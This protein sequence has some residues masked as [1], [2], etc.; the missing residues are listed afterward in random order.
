MKTNSSR[1]TVIITGGS[2]GIGRASAICLS[3]IGFDVIITWNSTDLKT[4]EIVKIIHEKGRFAAHLQLRLDHDDIHEKF[5]EIDRIRE[6][7]IVGLV[8]NAAINGGRAHFEQKSLQDWQEVFQVNVFSLVELCKVVFERMALSKGGNGGS[9]VNLSSQV[10][11]FGAN[12]LLVYAASKGA[13]NAITVALA[14]EIGHEGIRVNAVSPG[15]I[16]TEDELLLN[17]QL[18]LKISQ[19]P[20]GRLGTPQDVGE[21]ISWLISTKSAYISGAIIPIHGAR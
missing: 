17:K 18:Q 15:L 1:G 13:V 10:A 9:I 2:S 3:E 6:S 4:S 8:N 12:N 21:L 11:N 19:I 16:D 14:K 7:P 5:K 20:L